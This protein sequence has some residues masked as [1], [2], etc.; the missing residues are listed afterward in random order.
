[1]RV[2]HN[3]VI[4]KVIALIGA[5]LLVFSFTGAIRPPF[6]TYIESIGI[7]F[8]VVGLVKY[9]R[10]R[11][12]MKDEAAAVEFET[13]QSEERSIFITVKASRSV[14]F[15]STYIQ[16]AA[17]LVFAYLDY[18]LVSLVLCTLTALQCLAYAIVWRVLDKKY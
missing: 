9:L 11:R 18:S 5:F 16:L 4:N 12:I 6:L 17:A 1:M 2:K 7:V 14:F 8:L 15:Y 10:L 3:C 13:R